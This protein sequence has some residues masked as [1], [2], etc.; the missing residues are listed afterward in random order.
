MKQ[1]NKK[2]N[3]ETK[4]SNQKTNIDNLVELLNVEP[5]LLWVTTGM[6][7]MSPGSADSWDVEFIDIWK[8]TGRDES[9][10]KKVE[11]YKYKIL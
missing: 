2:I 5:E 4:K 10:R 11:K 7:S 8:G 6:E 9:N 1:K 3:N